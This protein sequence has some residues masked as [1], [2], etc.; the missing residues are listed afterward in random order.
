M[1]GFESLA[2][3]GLSGLLSHISCKKHTSSSIVPCVNGMN[4]A[5]VILSKDPWF[6]TVCSFALKSKSRLSYA[7]AN[8][9]GD[10]RAFN[11]VRCSC[12][13]D[14]TM[15]CIDDAEILHPPWARAFTTRSG[16]F[17][18]SKKKPCTA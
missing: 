6:S 1:S 14:Q 15:L 4:V 17:T 3:L 5:V 13:R 11:K 10:E 7:I 9:P 18:D 12:T 2:P 8:N 16:A